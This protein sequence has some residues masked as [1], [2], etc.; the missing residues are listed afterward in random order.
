MSQA[1]RLTEASASPSA[2]SLARMRLAIA[3][4]IGLVCLTLAGAEGWRA[5]SSR[6]LQMDTA[7]VAAL[8]L[9]ETAAQHAEGAFDVAD[10][11][12]AG[13]VERM[14]SDG[15]SP[16]AMMRM[17]R[18]LAA[19]VAALPRLQDLIVVDAAGQ[20]LASS[21]SGS[22][23]EAD[24]RGMDLVAFHRLH[25]EPGAH[26]GKPQPSA[27]DGR[28][29]VTLSRRFDHPDGSFAGAVEAAID[30]EYFLGLYRR[31][32]IGPHGAMALYRDDDTLLVRQPPYK[33]PPRSLRTLG[34]TWEQALTGTSGTF[35]TPFTLDGHRRIIAYK[36]LQRFPLVL[37]NGAAVE[38]VLADW[39]T[40]T[41]VHAALLSV[42][43]AV[44]GLAGWHVLRQMGRTRR[45]EEAYRLLADHCAD[46]IFTLDAEQRVQY[47]TPSVR[48]RTGH[49]PEALVGTRLMRHVHPEDRT[50]VAAAY[51]AVMAG[52]GRGLVIHRLRHANG[53]W[54]WMEVELRL[55]SAPQGTAP[56]GIIAA[57]R[58]VSARKAA[59]GLLDA[60]QA[61]LQAVFEHTTDCLFV[62]RV[63]PDGGFAVERINSA[64]ANSLGITAHD[65]IGCSP[66]ALFGEA[67][68]DLAE[69]GLHQTLEAR[70]A[71]WAEH[72]ADGI[73][74][75]IIQVP[76]PGVGGAIERILV[77]ARDI[78]EQ[79][80]VQE[81]ELLLRASEEQ[82]RLAAEAANERLDRLARH[83]ARARDR[84]E[85]ANQAKTHF[86]TSMSHEL[87]T[88]LNGILGYAQLL[89]MEG[90]LR[91]AQAG[92][93]E[94]MLAAGRHLLDMITGVLD[95]AQI[96]ADKITLQPAEVNVLDLVHACLGQVRPVAEAKGLALTFSAP[97]DA[98]TRLHADPLRLRQVLLNLLGNAVK[99]TPAG[100]VE[101]R[102]SWS[103]DGSAT[104]V[105]VADTGP[106]IPAVQRGRLFEAFERMDDEVTAVTEGAGLGL[107]ISAHLVNAMGGRIGCDARADGDGA[108]FW[109]ELPVERQAAAE[110]AAPPA[111][112]AAGP[113]LHLLVVDDIAANRDIACAFL[114][115]AGHQ[116]V[117]A[118]GGEAA[119]QL[120][121]VN[122]YDVILM[123]VRMPG[124]DGLE[125]TRRIRTLPG[126]RG[127]VPVVAVTAQAFAEQIEKCRE[128]GM[129]HHLAK[130]FEMAG[131][132][133]A[134]TTASGMV[135][136]PHSAP[137]LVPAAEALM[138]VL[139]QSL[140]D[141]TAA[142]LPADELGQH[143]LALAARGRVLL[144]TLQAGEPFMEAAELAHAMAGAAGTFGFQQI[145]DRGRRFEHAYEIGAPEQAALAAALVETTHATIAA[146]ERM[147][148]TPAHA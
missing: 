144:E 118:D 8:N 33:G 87:R 68:G 102:L 3:I 96:E 45:T 97:P 82:R 14:E 56:A 13:I 25:A 46:V 71:L 121:A 78:S 50:A 95:M 123:D 49:T 138:P 23:A 60:E 115:A 22:P 15:A 40:E 145:A 69:A 41:A 51:Q 47:V 26:V 98:P 85:Q 79:K 99:F 117:S 114:R 129:D 36:H 62:Q 111:S 58:D 127:L 100:S 9:A 39:W 63:L 146:L 2:P 7:R 86:L 125:A 21:L 67:R 74:W 89:R 12:L 29:V 133:E 103:A 91:P 16:D 122:D 88:P 65:A 136:R 139:N 18:V 10:A 106:G 141:D 112:P 81:A 38:D 27:R 48:E 55:M 128:A 90:G 66:Q 4:L 53:Y 147:T 137:T 30:L 43:L 126:R 109:L 20:W 37:F 134:V 28:M 52:E 19:R 64:A 6:S 61:F 76:I 124:M 131:L 83:L 132:L 130:P 11:V 77:N 31:L 108:V 140:F 104:R 73:T 75:D 70:Q 44:V 1:V 113:S 110:H 105:E 57:A 101:V 35:E 93:V 94:A 72:Q 142:Y 148:L 143:L 80:R 135:R 42:F 107:A 24:S 59:E 120:G 5:W 17:H 54:V 84:A 119:V 92:H 116:V 32:S 34:D